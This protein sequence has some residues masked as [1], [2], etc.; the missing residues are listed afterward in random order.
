M[1]DYLIFF[2][3]VLGI[4]L[5]PAF[6]PPTWSVIVLYALNSHHP[7][8]LLIPLAALAAALGRLLLAHAFRQL[9]ARLSKKRRDSLDAVRGAIERHRHGAILGLAFFALSPLPSA[10]LFEA[11]GLMKIRLLPFTL[12]FFVGRICA[13]SI[14]GATARSLTQTSLGETFRSALTSPIGIAVQLATIALL[15]ILARVDWAARL[16]IEPAAAKQASRD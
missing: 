1:I 2:A 12:A 16:H 11:A 7:L 5:L 9:G 6:G 3:V 13:Y 8:V 4:N 15:V 14:Y 10:Q